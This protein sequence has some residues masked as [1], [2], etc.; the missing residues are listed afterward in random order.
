MLKSRLVSCWLLVF[1]VILVYT[2]VPPTN[3]QILA[4]FPTTFI[5][6]FVQLLPSFISKATASEVLHST[7]DLPCLSAT[8]QVSHMMKT[9]TTS[10]SDDAQQMQYNNKCMV[11]F[12]DPVHR[13]MFGHFLRSE[14][15][16]GDTIDKLK[17]LL[18]LL[19]DFSDHPR[20]VEMARVTPLLLK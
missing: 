20:V 12:Q 13:L 5:A 11:A 19:E 2:Y 9:A 18:N 8:L 16:R 6:E 14:S 17:T 4:W 15:G 7:F 3:T 1:I 10:S